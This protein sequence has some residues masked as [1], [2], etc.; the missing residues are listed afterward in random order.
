MFDKAAPAVERMMFSAYWE[1]G[2]AVILT[3]EEVATLPD[4]GLCLASWA[5]KL[6]KQCGRPIT[7]GSGRR[8]MDP[9]AF[10][11]GEETKR[12]SIERYGGIEL[13]VIGDAARLLLAEVVRRHVA[14]DQL[15][16]W[17]FDIAAAF[18]KL[19]YDPELVHHIGV[20]L[21]DDLYMFFLAGV[22]GLTSMPFAFNVITRAVVWELNHR[23]LSGRGLQYVDDGLICSLRSEMRHEQAAV[24]RFLVGL[25]GEDAMAKHKL[26]EGPRL[27]FIGYL[28]DTSTLNISVSDRNIKKAIHAF[29]ST[30]LTQGARVPVKHLQKLAS[31]GSRYSS[32]CLLLR[33]FTRVLYASY[34]GRSE[35][36][37]VPLSALC[38]A[39]IR[40]FRN[41]FVM[42]GVRPL[43]F[44]RTFQSFVTEPHQW[45]CEFDASLSGIGLLW[46]EVVH[47]REIA[48]AHASVDITSLR[49]GEDAS[50]QN[51][52]EYI[53]SLMGVRGLDRLGARGC[54]VLFRG[55]SCTALSWVL[56]GSVRS[57]NALR[58]AVVW[59]Q[60]A[61]VSGFKV[62]DT[63]HLPADVN[64][65]TDI[66]SRG[67]SWADVVA[68]DSLRYGGTLPPSLQP[69][70]L[71]EG[72]LLQLVDPRLPL[73]SDD[74]FNSFF[75]DSLKHLSP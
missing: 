13:P 23:I 6:G 55:D 24:E 61:M 36:A 73:D 57:D 47:G 68:E 70:P 8:G 5:P 64:T 20:E 43:A 65:R 75:A 38:I 28:V 45:V 12:L 54:P 39:V 31:L 22:F 1:E 10:I 17:T 67:G 60:Y 62:T 74:L 59:A 16:L 30:D 3:K 21:R 9:S 35:A 27:T 18:L 49:F 72:P 48:R 29:Q 11:N 53:A 40:M 52:A 41:M 19:S 44:T 33:P 46:F 56:K 14:A 51:T 37:S 32:I 58:A 66:L 50:F 4:V 7:N 2:L 15:E 63:V 69:L 34:T 26:A 25:L 42:M 71:D